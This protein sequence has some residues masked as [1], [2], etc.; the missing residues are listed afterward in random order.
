MATV[1]LI[2]NW[3]PPTRE[4]YELILSLWKWFPV[5]ASL[6][7][8][9]PW[10]GMGK[11]SVTSRLNLP[12]RIGWLTMESPG[13]LTL[14]YTFSTLPSQLF[15]S[16]SPIL[17]KE[18]LPWQN[19][20]LAFLF[21]LHYTYRALLFPFL[22]PSMSPLHIVIWVAG[23]GFQV[24]NGLMLGAWLGGYGPTTQAEWASQLS[25]PGGWG[26]G[27]VQFVV[28]LGVFY[29]GLAANYYH[30]DELREIRRRAGRRAREVAAKDGKPGPNQGQGQSEKGAGKG[31][32]KHYEIPQ[33]GLFKVMLY[34]HYFVEWVEWFGFWMAAGWG[35]VPAR[36]FVLNE[37]A[38]MLPRAVSGRKWYAEKF[39]EERIRGRWAVI[40]GVW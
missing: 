31:V 9:I 10:Y 30:D 1:G 16:T 34:P 35:C 27:M 19:K 39:G 22:Q 23:A 29:V 28:G 11:T 21:V 4:N 33:A 25:F 36:C 2:P 7:W 14:L 40:P 26:G 32:D 15:S 20:V 3:Y 17:E 18:G 6:Q 24:V 37:I 5:F 13:F 8:A 38:A 12:G